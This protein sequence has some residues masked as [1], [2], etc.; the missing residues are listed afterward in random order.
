MRSC[1]DSHYKLTDFLNL[2]GITKN[3]DDQTI[4]INLGVADIISNKLMMKNA[5]TLFFSN[6][7]SLLCEQATVTCA[8]FD[9]TERIN[10]LNRKDYTEDIITNIRS[11]LHFIK[12]ELKVR[13]IITES[14]ERTEIYEIPLE[15]LREAIINAVSHRD[16]FQCGSHTTVEVFNDRI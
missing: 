11:A 6:S 10:I 3:L 4:L 13:Y 9:G 14:P 2:A 15:A 8:T 12:Q 16:Y 5:G 7:T 1:T